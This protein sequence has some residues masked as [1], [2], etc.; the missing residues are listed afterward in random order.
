MGAGGYRLNFQVLW[1]CDDDPGGTVSDPGRIDLVDGSGS[2]IAQ[3]LATAG[4]SGPS[5]SV[6]GAGTVS[7]ATASIHLY[8][9]GSTPADGTVH[10]TWTLVGL[11]PGTYSLRFWYFQVMVSRNPL[12]AVETNAMD[13]GGSGTIGGTPTPT[14]TP[15]PTPT[16]PPPAVGLAAPSSATVFQTVSVSATAAASSGA[17]PLASV[18]IDASW[19]NGSSWGVVAAN[20]HPSNPSDSESA[21]YTLRGAGVVLLRA[22]ATDARGLAATSSQSVAVAKANQGTVTVSPSAV[23]ITAGQSVAFSASG[24]STG[25]YAWGG[26]AGGLGPAQTVT[27]PAAGSY[28]VTVLDQGNATFN[29]SPSASAAVSVQNPFYTLS[30]S[31]SGVGTVSGAGSYRPNAEATAFATP[32][33]GNA[34]AGWTGDAT[35]ATPSLSILMS[36]NRSVMAHFSPLLTQTITY[37]PPGAVSTRSPAFALGVTASS[38]LPVSLALDSGPATLAGNVVTPTGTAGEVTITATQPGNA[39]YLPAPPVVIAFAIGPPPPGVILRDD[40][41][42]TKK[43]DKDTPVTSFTSGGAH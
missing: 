10:G 7:G 3:L 32:G 13:A 21:S 16:P 11:A 43:S 24:G 37:A 23:S 17:S 5:I 22:V 29:P 20:T 30:V 25:N 18:E 28:A 42:A 19:D 2:L 12:S 6:S 27:F 15:S 33:A 8:G 39:Q 4:R 38:G 34:F 9:A 31:A 26:S 35:A 41:A 40:S 14:P 1:T 36:G